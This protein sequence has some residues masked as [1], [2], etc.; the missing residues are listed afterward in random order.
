MERDQRVRQHRVVALVAA[1][2]LACVLAT[3]LVAALRPR[4]F[5]THQDAIGYVLERRSIS[6]TNIVVQHKWP[7]NV[8]TLFYAANVSV[9]LDDARRI[10][11]RLE[12][13]TP[14]GRRCIVMLREIGVVAEPLPEL[15]VARRWSW[16]A[17]VQNLLPQ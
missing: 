2:V 9:Q 4:T 12:C 13:Q 3:A 14:D 7:D 17:W 5:T 11:G 6:Y 10:G 16:L 1:L 8:N 15:S